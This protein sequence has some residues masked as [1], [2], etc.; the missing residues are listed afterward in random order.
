MPRHRSLV[1][2]R[3]YD[4]QDELFADIAALEVKG[5]HSEAGGLLSPDSGWTLMVHST[6]VVAVLDVL[7]VAGEP[8]L[9][10][11][12]EPCPRC[13]S[14]RGSTPLPPYLLIGIGV[15]FVVALALAQFRLWSWLAGWA[16]VSG[17]VIRRLERAHHWRC[18]NCHFT[19]N[20]WAEDE[21]RAAA[22]RAAPE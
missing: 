3:H 5:I 17:L 18:L 12:V 21:R 19:W 22:R 11:D 13:L 15:A 20:T 9:Q 2:I 4:T 7:G 14:T 6:D 1:P 10:T 16:V 8:D